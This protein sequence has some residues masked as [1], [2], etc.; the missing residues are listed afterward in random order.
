MGFSSLIPY[1]NCLW[2]QITLCFGNS[3]TDKQNRLA[4]LDSQVNGKKGKFFSLANP[5][6]SVPN[7]GNGNPDQTAAHQQIFAT[8]GVF[9]YMSDTSIW[10]AFKDT[11]TCIEQALYNFDQTNNWGDQGEIDGTFNGQTFKYGLRS[12][13]TGWID[14]QLA[15]IEQN[16]R[17]WQQDSKTAYQNAFPPSNNAVGKSFLDNIMGGTGA[18]TAA[19]MKFPASAASKSSSKYGVWGSNSLP[20]PFP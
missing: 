14:A 13:Y 12:L 2:Y 15:K 1:Q 8:G 18:L 6:T 5:D 10:Q 7:D 3:G 20:P 17:N 16:G 4:L 9:T 19:G 11:S